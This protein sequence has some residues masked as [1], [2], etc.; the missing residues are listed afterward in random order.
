MAV[1]HVDTW[2]VA[3]RGLLP[4]SYLTS[5]SVEARAAMWTRILDDGALVCVA[6]RAGQLLGFAVT[7]D[8]RDE[9]AGPLVGELFALYVHPTAW[10]TGVGR[11]LHDDAL[12]VSTEAGHREATLWVLDTNDRAREFYQR[13]GW[14]PD[15]AEKTDERPGAVL[16]EVRYRRNLLT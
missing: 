15:G 10:S 1:V 9:D 8:S 6:E 7:G 3:Y 12:S 4:A 13:H 14:L 2:Q 16:H 5:L 11:R